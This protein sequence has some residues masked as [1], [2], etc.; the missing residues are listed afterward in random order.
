MEDLFSGRRGRALGGA[1]KRRGRRTDSKT[2]DVVGI[3]GIQ[4]TFFV[5]EAPVVAT[6]EVVGVSDPPLYFVTREVDA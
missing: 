6:G 2:T 4:T 3:Q 1:P 5:S